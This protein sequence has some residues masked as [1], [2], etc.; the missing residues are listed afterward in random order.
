MTDK[1]KKITVSVPSADIR[2]VD[3]AKV[4]AEL[5]DTEPVTRQT[6]YSWVN[7]GKRGP[8]GEQIYLETTYR[9]GVQVTS[10]PWIRDFVKGLNG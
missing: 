10:L 5:M 6:V 9:N 4:A 8:G 1:T 3:V 7:N 2:L